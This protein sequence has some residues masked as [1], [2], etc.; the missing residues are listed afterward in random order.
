[1]RR[2]RH[3]PSSG[4]A[5]ALLRVGFAFV[6]LV[7]LAWLWGD[8]AFFYSTES[9]SSPLPTLAS[10]Y[11]PDLVQL[12]YGIWLAS[13]L[14]L[15]VG[16]FTRWAAAG[17]FIGCLYFLV[18]R[19]PH[20]THAADWL[21]PNFAFHVALLSSNRY[22]SLDRRWRAH[23]VP[24]RVA[25]WPL[26]LAQLSVAFFYFT[27][28]TSKL[29][30]PIWRHGKGFFMTFANPGLSHYD[31]T[32]LATMPV[33]SA[34]LNYFVVVWECAMPL[35]L[36]W[37]RTRLFAVLSAAFFLVTVDINLPVGWFAWFCLAN[38]L[39]FVD[40]TPWL[41]AI[42]QRSRWLAVAPNVTVETPSTGLKERLVSAFLVFH[43]SS[44]AWMQLAYGWIAV[45]NYAMGLRL[46]SVPVVGTYGYAIA[47][48]RYYALWPS[49]VF[50][51]LRLVYLEL[52]AQGKS[53]HA[54]PPFD[55]AG[56]AHIG[57][58]ESRNVREQVMVSL[59]LSESG[60]RRYLARVGQRFRDRTGDCPEHLRAYLLTV[61]PGSFGADLRRNKAPLQQAWLACT[62]DDEVV[63]TGSGAVGPTAE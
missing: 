26:R 28:G 33:V 36:L 6:L 51:R 11:R 7:Q 49:E 43:L 27:A 8:V 60:W 9:P 20:A 52:E 58:L 4:R 34:A 3:A 2:L 63:V 15:L 40:D 46:A 54:L 18:L 48:V 13:A 38:L 1:M 53:A 10:F 23:T 16:W 45:G 61:E 37:R 42:A 62:S 22:L 35:L 5:E 31:F 55:D 21:I 32:W 19:Q 50:Y 47:N 41:A 29:G 14:L 59:G 25:A 30:D 24:A 57:W 56:R 17:C 39:A 12:G 44:F